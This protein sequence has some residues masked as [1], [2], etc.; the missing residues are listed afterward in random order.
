MAA[1]NQALAEHCVLVSRLGQ[2]CLGSASD[3]LLLSAA[4]QPQAM[5]TP[6]RGEL[7]GASWPVLS[8]S[9][10]VV[11]AKALAHTVLNCSVEGRSFVV[12]NPCETVRCLTDQGLGQQCSEWLG[13]RINI[14]RIV[15][16]S[17]VSWVHES[18]QTLS[19]WDSQSTVHRVKPPVSSSARACRT[20]SKSSRRVTALQDSQ[21]AAQ[22][23]SSSQ[24]ILCQRRDKAL[25]ECPTR[26]AALQHLAGAPI[27]SFTYC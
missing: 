7:S 14:R 20:P 15:L 9:Q 10:V 23:F 16:T 12:T 1:A 25:G 19:A 2:P 17:C 21:L 26:A 5:I 3:F 27:R 24:G 6:R 18:G 11:S 4:H 8:R 22:I 13:S